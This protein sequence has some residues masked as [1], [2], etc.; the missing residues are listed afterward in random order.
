[1]VTA[2]GRLSRAS[3]LDV[4]SRQIVGS[5][6]GE[7]HDAKLAH[8]ALTTAIA[9]RG[10][11]GAVAGVVHPGQGTAAGGTSWLGGERGR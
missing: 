2:G 10:G 3:V 7:H 8:V 4:A 1:M 11:L 9:M 5:T 6:L